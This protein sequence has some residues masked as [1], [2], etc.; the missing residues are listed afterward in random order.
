MP[1]RETRSC[2]ISTVGRQLE[3]HRRRIGWCV[4]LQLKQVQEQIQRNAPR[5]RI[6]RMLNGSSQPIHRSLI[7]EY[8]VNHSLASYFR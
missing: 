4:L 6:R 1:C 7:V 3:Q 8:E 5:H 2:S